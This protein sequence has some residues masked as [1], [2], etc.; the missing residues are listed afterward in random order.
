VNVRHLP[1]HFV[2]VLFVF[3]HIPASNVEKRIIFRAAGNGISGVPD[4]GL[5]VFVCWYLMAA[6]SFDCGGESHERLAQINDGTGYNL[7]N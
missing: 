1:F 2:H 6:A 4:G 5:S 3:I 7:R